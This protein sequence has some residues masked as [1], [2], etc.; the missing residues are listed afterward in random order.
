MRLPRGADIKESEDLIYFAAETA[1]RRLTNRIIGS[2]YSPDNVDITLLAESVP[3]P[4]ITSL[5]QLLAL[6]SELN[7]QLDQ[8]YSTIP[9]QPPIEVDS[10]SDERR[11]RLHLRSLCARQLIHRP[12]ILYVALQPTYMA[13]SDQG[14]AR[15][16]RSP[17]PH[18]SPYH[19]PRIMLER[20]QVCIQS[21][22]AYILNAA[23]VLD[24]RTPYLWS[25]SQ[26]CVA[27]FALLFLASRSPHLRHLVPDLDTLAGA[28]APKIRQWATLGS[29]FEA[30]LRVVDMLLAS[31][32]R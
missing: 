20:C 5:N 17:T 24:K 11:R 19:V 29:S 12:F 7:R 15:S 13:S 32:R 22:A 28:F 21:C 14:Q 2:L 31:R 25:V 8:Y 30:L 4:N 10:A 26:C 9:I 23:D 18:H 1:I 3:M 16:S 6:S 27:S